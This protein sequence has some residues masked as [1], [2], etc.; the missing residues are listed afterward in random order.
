VRTHHPLT[1]CAM[2][3]RQADLLGKVRAAAD[4][5]FA[6]IGITVEDYL[7]AHRAGTSDRDL[8]AAVAHSGVDVV[9]IESP[10][11]W[12]IADIDDTAAAT[13]EALFRAVDAMGCQQVNLVQF[14]AHPVDQLRLGLDRVADRPARF[15][16]RIAVEFMPFSELRTLAEASALVA[17]CTQPVG[18][19]LDVWHLARS[20]GGASD[21]R[22]VPPG[23]IASV[24]LNDAG[25]Q[26]HDDP[27]HEARHHRLLPG[28]GVLDLA[29]VLSEL[30]RSGHRP[31]FSV[32]VWSDALLA[33]PAPIAARQAREAT[34]RV[35]AVSRPAG[36][37][38]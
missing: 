23:V 35:L 20:G 33:L 11:D 19:V 22:S 9:E 38:R 34:E 14:A 29:A 3:V 31:R 16:A 26:P 15:G 32:E 7:D 24:Q 30:D 36:C 27:K 2:T 25:P 28:E 8:R 18:V 1:L 6:G 5:G 10:W 12:A 4:A 13:E 37:A 17:G 21:V